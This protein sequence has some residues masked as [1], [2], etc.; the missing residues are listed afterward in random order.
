MSADRGYRPVAD[1][2][3]IGDG[4]T[5]ALVASDGS[6]DWLC[7]PDIDSDAVFCRLLDDRKGGFFRVGPRSEHSSARRYLGD[8]NVLVTTF[9]TPTGVVQLTDLMPAPGAAL[10]S[11][12]LRLVE[13]VSGTVDVEIE[14]RATFGYAAASTETVTTANGAVASSGHEQLTLRAPAALSADGLGGA[15]AVTSVRAGDRFWVTATLEPTS[16]AQLAAVDGDAVLEETLDYWRQWSARCTY[17]GPYHDLVRRS[18]LTL[19]LL[20]FAPTGAVVAAPT[21]SLPEEVGGVRNWDYRYAWLRDASLMLYA[22]QSIGYHDE[23]DAFFGWLE[24]LCL[25]SRD[26][27][28]IMYTVN[29]GDELTEGTLDHLD[30]WRSSRP[31]RVGNAAAGQTQLDVYGEILDA[32]HLH[33]DAMPEAFDASTWEVLALLADRAAQRWRE[34]DEGIWEVR[35]GQ[36]HFLYSKLL[37]WVALDRALQIADAHDAPGDRSLWKS[38]RDAIREAI[39]TDG[40]NAEIGAFTQAFGETTLDA[41]ALALS[42]VGFLPPTDARVRSTVAAIQERLTS[43]GLVYRYLPEHTPDGLPGGEATFV[44][45]SFWLVDNLALA[46]QVGEARALFERVA[47]YANDVHLFAEEIDPASG[48]LLGNFPQGFTHL[49]LI[50]SAFAIAEAESAGPEQEPQTYAGR[51]RR[52]H[53]RAD[54][55]RRS[56]AQARP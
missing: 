3:V 6:I 46:G 15:R 27:V 50:R 25:A 34:P 45:C 11:T 37:C 47:G 36:R 29:G 16:G 1:Y 5:V 28:Q 7:V 31:V 20:A 42:T 19:K 24:R 17:Q 44:M 18:A 33:L 12:V 9:T 39:L 23:A 13:G 26:R 40:W 8:T 22:L 35:G 55:R 51:I 21:T 56:H 43:D 32:A 38:E 30:G 54:V 10:P 49:A 4:R 14:L 52:T 2:A 41:S 48:E 53:G